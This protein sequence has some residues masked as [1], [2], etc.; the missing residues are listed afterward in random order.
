MLLRRKCS[1]CGAY[2]GDDL[3]SRLDSET[4][5]LGKALNSILVRSQQV[6]HLLIQLAHV[7]FE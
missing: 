4:R 1:R 6:C 5:H 7:A 2:L 3:M